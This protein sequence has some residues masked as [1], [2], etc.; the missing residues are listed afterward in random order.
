M[1]VVAELMPAGEPKHLEVIKYPMVR[2]LISE[3]GRPRMLLML[4]I[5]IRDFCS[6]VNVV[7]NMNEDQI[8]EAAAMLLDECGN[9]RLEDYTMM[10]A[11]A[12]RGQLVKIYDRIDIQ[13]INEILDKYWEQ[14]N[15]A[16]KRAQQEEADH[17][18]NGVPQIG[19]SNRQLTFDPQ[20]GYMET[21]PKDGLAAISGAMAYLK[22]QMVEAKLVDRDENA[23][24]K[25]LQ[26][27]F[28]SGGGDGKVDEGGH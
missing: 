5:M 28:R 12:K 19:S 3:Q 21:T 18:E 16:G 20:R 13:V 6:S 15:A 24:R 1:D 17:L 27:N 8:I 10:F 2:T 14:R 9:F 26:P 25:Q 4:S 7:R 11:L 23:A 22:E